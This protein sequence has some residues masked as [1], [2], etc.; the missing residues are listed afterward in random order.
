MINNKRIL[1]SDVSHA[2]GDTYYGRGKQYFEDDR[3][4]DFEI[5]KDDETFVLFKSFIKGSGRKSYHQRVRID[6][7][8]E[9]TTVI[10][11]GDCTCPIAYNCKHITAACLEYIH[12]SP[13]MLR[14]KTDIP[15][16]LDWLNQLDDKP[17]SIQQDQEFIVYVLQASK[18]KYI[19]TL[20]FFIS[21]VNK[22]GGLN[23]G[24]KTTLN[25][26]RYSFTYANYIQAVDKEI[27]QLLYSL[28]IDYTGSP[29]L[30]GSPG[31]IALSK[32][33]H[34]GR[35]FWQS[36]QSTPLHLDSERELIFSWQQEKKGDYQLSLLIEPNA[37]LIYTE[38]CMYLDTQQHTLGT[39]KELHLSHTQLKQVLSAPVVPKQYAEEFSQRLTLEYP[40]IPLP[41]PKKLSLQKF[42]VLCLFPK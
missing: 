19:F 37:E 5:I 41:A 18:M 35:L 21:K 23:K 36:H 14:P 33:V 30:V 16:C 20:E 4:L 34:T 24:R 10:I 15:P 28:E 29:Q 25:N 17:N 42:R 26:L 27:G 7:K 12:V 38:P 6:W 39:I 22:S 8:D 1:H 9:F 40:S 2:C 3:I 11:D 32:I 31:F 13:E